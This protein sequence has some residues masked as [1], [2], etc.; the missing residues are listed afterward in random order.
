MKKHILLSLT[1]MLCAS[2]TAQVS[3]LADDVEYRTELNAQF[4]NGDNA[5]F[6]FSA[7]RYGLATTNDK[8]GYL[9]ASIERNI[10]S[11]SQRNWRIGYGADIA[12]PANYNSHFIVQQLYGEV[13]Y[14]AVRLTVGQKERPLEMKNQQLTSGGMAMGINARPIPQVRLELADFFVIKKTNNWIA[15]KGHLAYGAYTDNKWQREFN[16][17]NKEAV[18]N[19]NS[20]YHSKA[21]YLRIGNTEQ[22]PLVFT[23]GVE[24]VCQFGGTV[25]NRNIKGS[26]PDGSYKLYTGVGDFFKAFIPS[27]SDVTD[28]DNP[29]VMGNTVGSYQAR[30][31]YHGNGWDAS[32]YGEHFFEDHSQMGW[33]FA[34]KDFLWGAE[35][36]L[37]KNPFV[38]TIVA[39]HMRTTDQSGPVLTAYG[40]KVHNIGGQDNYY[41]HNIYGSYQHAGFVMGSPLLLSPI[42]NNDG[43]IVCRDN[44]ITAWHLGIKG[45][46]V[47]DVSYRILFTHEKSLGNFNLPHDNPNKGD[48]L[49]VET[50]YKPQQLKGFAFTASYG[51]NH[52]ELLGN[53]HGGMLTVSYN[54]WINRK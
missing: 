50:T 26:A 1:S 41:N 32:I 46:P 13:Q 43:R 49:L 35:V 2:A 10:E 22:F 16:G 47:Q 28:G 9:R 8:G 39:E 6:W 15:L 24:M 11:D 19:A 53:T 20:L 12:V 52:G 21:G 31:D 14:K 30:L 3:R 38:S 48:F 7:N 40:D 51:M 25:W 29:N 34:W 37:P 18:Y 17:G 5:P 54:G 33:D 45:E 44:R 42:Y 23:G 4:S 36:N 27:G